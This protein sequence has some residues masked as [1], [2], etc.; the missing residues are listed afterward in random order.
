LRCLDSTC[1]Q[2]RKQAR[3]R[4]CKCIAENPVLAL[5]SIHVDV[6]GNYNPATEQSWGM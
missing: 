5:K 6:L 2:T 3:D 1:A 4:A